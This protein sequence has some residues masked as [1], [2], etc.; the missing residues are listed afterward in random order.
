MS[1]IEVLGALVLGAAAAVSTISTLG[2][3]KAAKAQARAAKRIERLRIQQMELDAK[4]ARRRFLR[5]AIISRAKVAGAA[6][7]AGILSS[8][9]V[10][11]SMMSITNIN[12]GN[13]RD[14]NQN[15]MIGRGIADARMDTINAQ[16]DAA[17]FGAIGS[18]GGTLFRTIGGISR[19]TA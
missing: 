19:L 18:L 8:S 5:Q 12:A 13:V 2:Q 11:G 16:S 14:T 3:L 4:R 1:G 7:S 17:T 15:L 9:P 6:G 10:A